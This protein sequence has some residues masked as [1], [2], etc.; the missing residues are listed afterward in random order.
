MTFE[1]FLFDKHCK[2]VKKII[3]LQTIE[4]RFT[5]VFD[6]QTDMKRFRMADVKNMTLKY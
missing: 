5:Y 6:I 2:N 4:T 1:T 3:K